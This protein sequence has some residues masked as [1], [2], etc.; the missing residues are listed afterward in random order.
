VVL[1]GVTHADMAE[2]IRVVNNVEDVVSGGGTYVGLP[3]SIE[4]PGEGEL[5]GEAGIAID[6]VDRRTVE[7]MR[8]IQTPS[9]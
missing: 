8:T 4:L 6:N 2:T 7:A 3:F 9:S 1:L 5:P